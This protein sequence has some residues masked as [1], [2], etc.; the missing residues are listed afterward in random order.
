[1][2]GTA[3]ILAAVA[4]GYVMG[5]KTGG[6][7]LNELGRSLNALRQTDEFA[8]VVSASRSQLAAMLRRTASMVDGAHGTPD[9]PGDLVARV[10]AL[11][12]DR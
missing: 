10:R 1:M 3:N 6:D 7:S 2:K 9:V 11:V 12:R 4:I 8:E 5:A